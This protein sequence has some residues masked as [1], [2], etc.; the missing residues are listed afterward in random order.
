LTLPVT[1][2]A[3][4]LA[5]AAYLPPEAVAEALQSD[6]IELQGE[7]GD[8]VRRLNDVRR[9]GLARHGLET[10]YCSDTMINA[11]SAPVL[12]ASGRAVLALTAVGEATRFRADL[13]GDFALALREAARE[14]SCRLGYGSDAAHQPSG[15]LAHSAGA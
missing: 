1:S 8:W 14:L 5:F 10:F 9:S 2:T 7:E 15:R 3:T 11:L 13:D 12:D 6:Q 4:G